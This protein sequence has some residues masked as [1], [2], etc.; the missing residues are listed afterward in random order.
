MASYG[1]CIIVCVVID[2][3]CTCLG[4]EGLNLNVLHVSLQHDECHCKW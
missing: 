3:M 1:A 4:G 2:H